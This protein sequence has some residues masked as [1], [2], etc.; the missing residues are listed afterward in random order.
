M[1]Q[2]VV[3]W[4]QFM[5]D[6][7][8]YAHGKD[9]D[10][11]KRIIVCI[12]FIHAVTPQTELGSDARGLRREILTLLESE[13]KP[14]YIDSLGCFTHNICALY[15]CYYIIIVRSIKIF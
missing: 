15:V 2:W 13:V 8:Q 5:E 4:T 1:L 10:P 6:I 12:I 11:V 7:L 9:F 3:R 14:K